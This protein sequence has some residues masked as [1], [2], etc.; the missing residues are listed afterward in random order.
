M[1]IDLLLY[2]HSVSHKDPTFLAMNCLNL[3]FKERKRKDLTVEAI[4]DVS[5]QGRS[6]RDD[7]ESP[8]AFNP[9]V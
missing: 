2:E 8:T 4:L 7:V 9:M 3:T 1:G 6:S 5:T